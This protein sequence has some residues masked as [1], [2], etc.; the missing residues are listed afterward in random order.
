MDKCSSEVSSFLLPLIQNNELRISAGKTIRPTTGFRILSTLRTASIYQGGHGIGANE[1]LRILLREFDK[2]TLREVDEE[3][4]VCIIKKKFS[5][6]SHATEL[7]HRILNSV[8]VI[9]EKLSKQK[10]FLDPKQITLREI[11]ALMNRSNLVIKE[12]VGEAIDDSTFLSYQ[13]Q[14]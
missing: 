3:Q 13:V 9:R 4:L 8:T 14:R 11:L 10:A 6:I 5:Y 1:S 2:V 12:I 7:I